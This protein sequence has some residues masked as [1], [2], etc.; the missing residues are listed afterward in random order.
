MD[1]ADV[2]KFLEAVQRGNL[3]VERAVEQLR[4]WPYEDLGFGPK[5]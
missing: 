2:R 3:P 5:D 1:E 4:Q